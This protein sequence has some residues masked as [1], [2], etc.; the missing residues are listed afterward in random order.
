M[1]DEHIKIH[2]LAF[3][4]SGCL[5]LHE[6]SAEKLSGLLSFSNKQPPVNSNFQC[7]LIGW[8]LKAGLTVHELPQTLS[9]GNMQNLI[10]TK[11]LCLQYYCFQLKISVAT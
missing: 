7:H 4:T 2:I 8:L 10:I 11:N 1:L 9:V 6:S 3:P 5:L